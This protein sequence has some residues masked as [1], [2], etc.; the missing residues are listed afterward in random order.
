[1]REFGYAEVRARGH[2][3]LLDGIQDRANA[4]G[5]GLLDVWMSHGDKVTKL[6]PGFAVMA[7]NEACPIAGMSTARATSTPSSSIPRSRIQQGRAI[8]S[9]LR[10]RD[11]RLRPALEHAG[12]RAARHRADPR[13]GGKR[14]RHPRALGGVDS[15]VAAALIHKAIGEQL[16][17]I[18]V[19]T[20][21][22]RL[23][24]ATR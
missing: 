9:P 19:D 24:E 12:V 5:H 21:L 23:D 6:P 11:L 3:L 7:S 14:G 15:A 1:V 20:G 16:T 8:Y 22:L 18:F 10:A 13:A 4:E 17:C 2:S